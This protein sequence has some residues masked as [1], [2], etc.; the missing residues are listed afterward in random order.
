M[1]I[2]NCNCNSRQHFGHKSNASLWLPPTASATNGQQLLPGKIFFK[3]IRWEP[4][5]S[6]RNQ[7]LLIMV[8]YVFNYAWALLAP[9][10]EWGESKRERERVVEILVLFRPASL[11]FHLEPC[12][13]RPQRKLTLKLSLIN[14]VNCR[15]NNLSPGQKWKFMQ[16]EEVRGSRVGLMVW[17]VS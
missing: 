13:R 9:D 17:Q 5:R 8:N 10:K 2:N 15:R 14:Y 3:L 12:G 11:H 1:F 16:E 6:H 7:T 4:G